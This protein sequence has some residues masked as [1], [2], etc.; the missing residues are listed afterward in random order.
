MGGTGRGTHAQ[1]CPG[2]RPEGRAAGQPF[3]ACRPL[4]LGD[5]SGEQGEPQGG[6]Q[7]PVAAPA[8]GIPRSWPSPSLASPGMGSRQ[9][10]GKRP[11]PPETPAPSLPLSPCWPQ[12]QA[13]T[14]TS[15][16][17]SKGNSFR[18]VPQSRDHRTPTSLLEADTKGRR[19]ETDRLAW[20]GREDKPSRTWTR[21]LASP[22]PKLQPS[23]HPH[24]TLTF[25]ARATGCRGCLGSRTRRGQ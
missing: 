1:R 16:F 15:N 3:Q 14:D 6:E 23:G 5:E 21:G 22:S 7:G 20:G 25:P 19:Q 13:A 17:P 9:G 12:S 18:L 4:P 2:A 8:G 11:V 24:P 10:Q